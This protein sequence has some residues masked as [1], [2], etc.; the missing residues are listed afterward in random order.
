MAHHHSGMRPGPKLP[1][2]LF[3]ASVLVSS[4]G[5]DTSNF[6][7]FM[8]YSDGACWSHIRA[9]GQGYGALEWPLP[10][11]EP[12]WTPSLPAPVSSLGWR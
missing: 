2:N 8:G 10:G 12:H 9:S 3:P 6:R 1:E 4:F 5:T 11:A 7:N